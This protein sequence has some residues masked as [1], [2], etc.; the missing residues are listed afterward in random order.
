VSESYEGA[1]P[2]GGSESS[3]GADSYGG[4]YESEADTQA[5]IADL[6]E[7]S[8]P[9]EP[10]AATG[11]DTPD[12][13]D[14][15]ELG[16]EY[17]ADTSAFLAWQD[18]LPTPQESRAARWGDNPD[19]DDETALAADYDN[20]P[21][22]LTP[23]GDSPVARLDPT[24]P[25]ADDSRAESAVQLED[26]ADSGTQDTGANNRD[27]DAAT[28]PDEPD[29]VGTDPATIETG[30]LASQGQDTAGPGEGALP[31]HA[32]QAEGPTGDDG[33]IS[34]SE[35]D[36]LKALEAGRAADKQTIAQ[37][38][39]KIA[40]QDAKLADQDE[41]IAE[42][43]ATIAGQGA[44]LKELRATVADQGATIIDQDRTIAEQ[45]AELKA[46][47]GDLTAVK[48]DVKAMKGDYAALSDRLEQLA[49]AGRQPESIDSPEQGTDQSGL[50]QL[51]DA[52]LDEHQGTSQEV[53]PKTAGGTRGARWRAVVAGETLTNVGTIMGSAAVLGQMATS[54]TPDG[55]LGL[56]AAVLGLA[57]LGKTQL[58]KSRK[59]RHD[60]ANQ[61]QAGEGAEGSNH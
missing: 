48:D 12:Y 33:E 36:R 4:Y 52:E 47:K 44:E 58:E 14:E 7:L 54:M 11:G 22:A 15:A 40:G 49:G 29:Q 53:D 31:G 27:Q 35:A 23:E 20:N 55:L 46:V 41:K 16:A 6:D 28:T 3:A 17:D 25:T 13:D 1:A 34:P 60:R 2:D 32:D 21:S 19:Y 57:G 10:G 37:L 56:G 39:A 61:Q 9:Q 38:E 30:L 42:K 51:A 8:A 5:R 59:E 26:P 24:S 50:S 18:E 43:D 45:G